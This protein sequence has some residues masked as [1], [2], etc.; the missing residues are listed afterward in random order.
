MKKLAFLSVL[1]IASFVSYGNHLKGGWVYYE[2]LGEG[3]TPGTIS[4]R[5]TVKQYLDC[6][7]NPM[8]VDNEVF[9][10]IFNGSTNQLVKQITVANSGT[11]KIEKLS[12]NPCIFPQPVTCFRIDSYVT[13]VDLPSNSA[14]YVLAVQ[15]CCRIAGIQNVSNSSTIGVTYST[16]IP[17]TINGINF[18]KNNSPR[19]AQRDTVVICYNGSFTF[20]FGAVD[21][22]GDSLSYDFCT[23]LVGGGSGMTGPNSAKPNPPSNPPYSAVPYSG[24]YSGGSPM[25]PDVTIN[26]KT[27]LITGIAP[28]ITGDY[29]VAVCVT[30]YRNGV[31]IGETKKEIHITVASCSVSA[32]DL[33]PSYITCDG[34]TLDFKNLSTSPISSYTWQFGDPASGANNISTS[35]TPTHTYSDTGIY[36]LKLRVETP[37][38]C[39]DS[40]SRPVRIFPG[41]TPAFDVIGSCFASPFQFNDRTVTKYGVVD[42]WRWDFGDINSSDDTS[43][44]KNNTYKYQ[45]SGNRTASLVVTNSKG[46]TA[47]ITKPVVVNDFPLLTLPFKDTL[48]CSIDTLPIIAQGSGIFTWTPNINIINPG[49]SNPQVYPKDTITYYVTLNENG[50]VSKDSLKV[51]VLDFITVDAGRDTSICRT[52]SILLRPVSH[53]LQYVWSP[54]TDLSDPTIKNPVA[55]PLS[56]TR[57]Y[58][59]ANLGKC[60]HRD[61]VLIKVTPYPQAETGEDVTLCYGSRTQITGSIVGSSFTWS[62]TNSLQNPQTLTPVAGP[63]TTTNYILSSYDTLGCPK[64]HRDTLTVVVLPKILA[65]AGNDTSVVA[66]QPLQLKASG[67]TSYLWSPT[68]GMTGFNTATPVIT[69]GSDIESITYRVRVGIAEGCFADDDINVKIFKTGPEIFIPTAFTPNADRKNDILK[70]TL[71][72]MKGLTYFKIYNR[73]GQLIFNTAEEG[74]GW[75]GTFAGKQQAS[76]TYVFMAEATDYLDKKVFRKGTFVLIR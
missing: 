41:F 28:G 24:G 5:I 20:D 31:R 6:N 53:A 67:G 64:P 21:Q 46:C 15:R 54:A 43:S 61:S 73:W 45:N 30:E 2:A 62:P 48:I 40:A 23:G 1:L 38:G 26:S 51:N 59:T 56:T 75:D 71:V 42:S 66:N 35:A 8:Q 7:S 63:I 3:A 69:L 49:S 14:G 50:C 76:G 22:D 16:S 47:T 70:P 55:V 19:F 11:E 4:Y 18:E 27:G 65:F 33:E 57:Y 9:L 39:K 52:D 74:T 36:T 12:F 44:L 17:G 25:G 60:Q 72:G 34:Y 58:L 10:G 13:T 37:N 29:V 68:I 32:A